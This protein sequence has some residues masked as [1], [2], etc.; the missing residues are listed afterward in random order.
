[1]KLRK[2]IIFLFFCF[3]F[4]LSN[5]LSIENKILF[6]V[7]NE[8]ITSIDLLNEIEYLTLL[9]KNIEKLEKNK[10]FEIAKNS[11]VR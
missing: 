1:M 2:K 9:N 7:N 8:I 6:K 10:I 4:N 3:F 5:S 11:L